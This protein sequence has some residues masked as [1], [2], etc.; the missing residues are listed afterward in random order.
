MDNNKN[1]MMNTKITLFVVCIL[2]IIGCSH[3]EKRVPKDRF[4]AYTGGWGEMNIPLIKPFHL[5]CFDGKD[6]TLDGDL[7][8]GYKE[9]GGGCSIGGVQRFYASD[10]LFLFRSY[11]IFLAVVIK[12]ERLSE[13]WFIISIQNKTMNGYTDYEAFR[14][15]VF[16]KFQ[17]TIDTLSWRT[18][19][20][21]YNEF[22]KEGIMP[23]FPD[24]IW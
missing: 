7:G 4:Y 13:G 3:K 11:D 1:A 21:Y 14:D 20:S 5:I 12:G 9:D 2:L 18:P 23:W 10:S 17:I 16:S 15:T 8:A 19:R 6:W 22:K 24:S